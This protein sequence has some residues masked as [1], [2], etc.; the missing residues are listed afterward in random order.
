[1]GLRIVVSNVHFVFALC[2]CRSLPSSLSL[3]FLNFG[4]EVS[5]V[6]LR[7]PWVHRFSIWS[8]ILLTWSSLSLIN[9]AILVEDDLILII[10][11]IKRGVHILI[12]S[13]L[14]R[15]HIKNLTLLVKLDV[16]QVI[17]VD[18]EIL[19]ANLVGIEWLV[20]FHSLSN[21]L[22][23]HVSSSYLTLCK[24]ILLHSCALKWHSLPI[25]LLLCIGTDKASLQHVSHLLR[26]NMRLV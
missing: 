15:L 10:C 25:T 4:K 13:Y 19:L 2:R 22:P 12:H 9:I 7:I 8:C 23:F 21:D 6:K 24:K 5:K 14:I 26:N 11:H 20:W 3:L 1:M 18:L 17:P 16:S